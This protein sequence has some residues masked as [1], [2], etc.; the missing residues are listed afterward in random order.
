MYEGLYDYPK[1]ADK[2]S[3]LVSDIINLGDEVEN[4]NEKLL[5]FSIDFKNNQCYN[6][7]AIRD[8]AKAA[9]ARAFEIPVDLSMQNE[10]VAK[11]Q[12]PTTA[13]LKV[14]TQ[15]RKVFEERIAN[16]G[17]VER[18]ADAVDADGAGGSPTEGTAI[19]FDELGNPI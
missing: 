19:E 1:L 2:F 4:V 18:D 11:T 12:A 14:D 10:V 13:K 17:N 8:K 7:P 9:G 5:L 3:E 15:K 16:H 6:L